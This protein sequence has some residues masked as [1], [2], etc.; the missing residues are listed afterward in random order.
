MTDRTKRRVNL[1]EKSDAE[2]A[3]AASKAGRGGGTPSN[4]EAE[5]PVNPS[6]ANPSHGE[7]GRAKCLMNIPLVPEA[8]C[9][10]FIQTIHVYLWSPR[11]FKRTPRCNPVSIPIFGSHW[12]HSTPRPVPHPAWH[13]HPAHIGRPKSRP[14]SHDQMSVL[15][16]ESES[17]SVH[18]WCYFKAE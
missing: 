7:P 16:S 15:E 8:R 9:R 5:N 10:I 18:F 17:D 3:Q 12:S 2:D 4:A 14:N 11:V 1:Y 6:P 13:P